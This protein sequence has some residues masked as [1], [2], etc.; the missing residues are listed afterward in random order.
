M[1][2]DLRLIHSILG[3]NPRQQMMISDDSRLV[4]NASNSNLEFMEE[5][6]FHEADYERMKRGMKKLM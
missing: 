4:S 1:S 6:K 2:K 5:V 3:I